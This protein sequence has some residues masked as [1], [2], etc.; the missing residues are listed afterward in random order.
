MQLS[1][2]SFAY[3]DLVAC[4]FFYACLDTLYATEDT[5]KEEENIF[6]YLE[7]Q[8]HKSDNVWIKI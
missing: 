8:K 1:K 6:C 5:Y 4:L 2:K 7:Q 3:F